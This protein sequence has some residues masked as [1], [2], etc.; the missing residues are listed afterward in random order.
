MKLKY[1]L[2]GMGVGI[3]FA[4][5]ILATS[6]HVSSKTQLSDDEI[7]KRAENLGMVKQ[8]DTDLDD[9]I[10]PSVTPAAEPAKDP[11]AIP[12][13]QPTATP[14]AEPTVKPT[15]TKEVK[16]AKSP[17]SVP[18]DEP[19]TTNTDTSAATPE[20]NK[21]DQKGI[22]F[23]IT[24]GMTSEDV[25]NLLK[26]KG[27]IEDSKAFNQYLKINKYTTDINIGEYQI[28]KYSSYE[29]IAD[30]IITK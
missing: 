26:N 14:T 22:T 20:V 15:D 21:T 19:E 28:E 4:T 11:S 6:Y 7:I 18:A 30:A 2:R 17:D 10:K 29:D 24:S 3:L 25:S 27:I 13:V 5:V 23:R 9:I 12:T 16:P 1:Y 8:S